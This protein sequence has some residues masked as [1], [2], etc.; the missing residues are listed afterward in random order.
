MKKNVKKWRAC[1]G[2]RKGDKW[3]KTNRKK[4]IEKDEKGGRKKIIIT[5]HIYE[6]RKSGG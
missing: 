4:I 5:K 6:W 2:M 1:G 3:I